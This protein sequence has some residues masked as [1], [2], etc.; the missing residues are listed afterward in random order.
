MPWHDATVPGRGWVEL[1]ATTQRVRTESGFVVA[2]AEVLVS[3]EQRIVSGENYQLMQQ[4]IR[5]RQRTVRITRGASV[6]KARLLV[7]IEAPRAPGKQG[8][9]EFWSETLGV[10]CLDVYRWDVRRGRQE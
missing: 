6:R 8:W 7:R 9:L 5:N 2:Y 3:V 4:A 10:E 1:R